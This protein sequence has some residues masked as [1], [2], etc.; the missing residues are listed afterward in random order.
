MNE[1]LNEFRDIIKMMEAA[2]KLRPPGRFTERVM[3]QVVSAPG[4]SPGLWCVLRQTLTEMQD[5]SWTRFTHEFAEGQKSCSYFLLS[6]LFFFFI[7]AVL[8]SNVFY[9]GHVSNAMLSVLMEAIL[10]LVASTS[11]VA[12]GLM[13]AARIPEAVYW[14][15]RAVMVY[16]ILIIATAFLIQ[17]T[18]KTSPGSLMA[19]VFG[20]SGVLTGMILIKAL[21]NPMHKNSVLTR[22]LHNA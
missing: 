14:A 7:A 22:G 2:P 20:L 11:L 6:G 16:G 10:V 21:A 3:G 1:D 4:E 9:S 5:I 15:K 17:T 12:A 8:F 18:V 19:L 13:M